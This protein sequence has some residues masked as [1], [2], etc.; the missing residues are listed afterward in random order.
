[1]GKVFHETAI[2]KGLDQG[3]NRFQ[4]IRLLA[5]RARQKQKAVQGVKYHTAEQQEW[6]KQQSK[7]TIEA[8][9]ELENNELVLPEFVESLKPIAEDIETKP[10]E[11]KPEE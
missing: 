8:L 7:F 4:T 5:M 10:V 3:Y 9:T 6:V 11:D 1:M 2:K